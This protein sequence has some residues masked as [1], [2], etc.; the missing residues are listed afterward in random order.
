MSYV[1]NTGRNGNPQTTP[2]FE[3]TSRA[4]ATLL[5]G[6]QCPGGGAQGA[7]RLHPNWYAVLDVSGCKMLDLPK[8]VSSDSLQYL[9]G[10]QWKARPEARWKPHVQFLVGGNKTTRELIDPVK[11]KLVIRQND[12]TGQTVPY[13]LFAVRTDANGLALAAGAGIDLKITNALS[14]RVAG[15]EYVR[16]FSREP[17]NVRSQEGLRVSMGFVLTMGTW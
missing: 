12:G 13:E 8:N 2:V 17:E 4:Q 15:V 3:F 5:D 16:T 14:W 9:A 10:L 7:Y 1:D 11:K 6:G